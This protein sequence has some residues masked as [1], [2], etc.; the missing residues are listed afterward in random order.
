MNIISSVCDC[1]S[2]TVSLA[3]ELTKGVV[4]GGARGV[5]SAIRITESSVK[6]GYRTVQD[7][8]GAYLPEPYKKIADRFIAAS[9]VIAAYYI[10]LPLVFYAFWAGY[11][12]IRLFHP[13]P[14]SNE[15]Y[16]HIFTGIGLGSAIEVVRHGLKYL[17]TGDARHV[18]WALVSVAVATKC[19]YYGASFE[20]RA[21]EDHA[22][23]VKA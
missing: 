14:F 10:A 4:V 11:S 1:C 9:P 20:N 2:E 18:L 3:A 5:A 22:R 6:W 12:I 19:L 16:Q 13:K 17:A 23:A 7:Y 15:A 21:P 8:T